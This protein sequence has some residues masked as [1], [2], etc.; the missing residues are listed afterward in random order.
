M[1]LLSH[2]NAGGRP[3]WARWTAALALAAILLIPGQALLH[4]GLSVET[5]LGA[6]PHSQPA[7]HGHGQAAGVAVIG[8]CTSPE[9][10]AVRAEAVLAREDR[11]PTLFPALPFHDSPLWS[12]TA[13]DLRPLDPAR[14]HR[15]EAHRR[16]PLLRI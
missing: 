14:I 15:T 10:C 7:G 16:A 12:A 5:L 9:S 6:P 11:G 1:T 4:C 2:E 3:S 13:S 8:S